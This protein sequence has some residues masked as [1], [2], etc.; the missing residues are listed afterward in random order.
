MIH[1]P[2]IMRKKEVNHLSA[3]SSL[4]ESTML[5]KFVNEKRLYSHLFRSKYFGSG[6]LYIDGKKICQVKDVSIKA[7]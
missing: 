5:R 4:P 2:N 6:T 1:I 7:N 3:Y